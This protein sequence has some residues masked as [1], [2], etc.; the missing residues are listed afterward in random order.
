MT[1]YWRMFWFLCSLVG[2]VGLF[3]L[4]LMMGNIALDLVCDEKDGIGGFFIGLLT[5][6]FT[7]ACLMLVAGWLTGTI[8][9]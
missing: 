5:V 9:P 3:A 7:V 8:R 1:D 6:V 2:A 4:A